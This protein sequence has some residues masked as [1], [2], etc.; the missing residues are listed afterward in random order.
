[1]CTPPRLRTACG[2]ARAPGPLARLDWSGCCGSVTSG[3]LERPAVERGEQ[4]RLRV[5]RLRG[6]PSEA[7]VGR[8]PPLP[9]LLVDGQVGHGAAGHRA[10][11][12]APGLLCP[13]PRATSCSTPLPKRTSHPSH[14]PLAAM[15]LRAGGA[16]DPRGS[17]RG[18]GRWARVPSRRPLLRAC[19]SRPTG[20]N[21]FRSLAGGPAGRDPTPSGAGAPSRTRAAAWGSRE[22]PGRCREG[23]A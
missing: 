15:E 22:S 1:M 9:G 6:R 19:S 20:G 13:G 18:S 12:L 10:R 23:S 3:G 8:G 5:Q 21:S 17:R 2:T 16:K 7:N 11:A 14:R 4:S